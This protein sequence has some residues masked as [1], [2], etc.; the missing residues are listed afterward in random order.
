MF[1]TEISDSIAVLRLNHG[2]VN[3]MDFDFCQGLVEKLNNLTENCNAVVLTS[4]TKVFS[5]GV[6]L[7]RLISEPKSYV[8]PFLDALDEC[9]WTL[10]QFPLPLVA[11]INGHAVAGGCVMA[12]AC[13]FRVIGARTRIGVPEL[14]VGVPFPPIALETMRLVASGQAF[15]SMIS[16]G[17]TYRDEQAIEVGL[18]DRL[19]DRESVLETAIA[20]A[21]QLTAIPTNVFTVTKRNVRLPAVQNARMGESELG[22][23]VRKIWESDE[24]RKVIE[25]YVNR[26]L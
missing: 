3:A 12:S 16:V 23:E 6:D 20:Q 18:A 19:V 26:K 24:L 13:D 17:A 5:A 2:K 7:K 14:R 21:K 8:R 22:S 10:F 25:E 4:S 15:Q 9:F 11:A 1:E